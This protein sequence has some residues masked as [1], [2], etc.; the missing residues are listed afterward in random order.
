MVGV[1]AHVVAYAGADRFRYG[2]EI[3]EHVDN[4]LLGKLRSVLGE[5]VQ[6]GDI[7]LMMP[8]VV[9]LHGP[10]VDMRL[11]RV[12]GIAER[13]ELERAR[14]RRRS[15]GRSGSGLGKHEARRGSSGHDA[16]SGAE[17]MTAGDR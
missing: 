16:G 10:G 2:G 11:Q 14:W 8:R 15:C 9:D 6:V 5:T 1:A 17:Q 3:A 13:R 7:G 12:E 4:G